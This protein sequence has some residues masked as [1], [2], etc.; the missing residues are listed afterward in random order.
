MNIW[1]QFAT[2]IDG[3]FKEGYSWKSDSTTFEY[4]NWKIIFDNYTLWSG[5][6]SAEMTRVIAPIT[7]KE[8]FRFEIYNESFVRKIEKV[9]GAQDIVIG[10]EDFDKTFIVKSNN[11]FKIKTLLRNK[12]LRNLVKIQKEVNIQ[13]LNEKGI[14]EEKLP[15]NE[16]ELSYFISGEIKNIETLKSLL[17]LFKIMLDELYE[18][19]SIH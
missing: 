1:K 13:I 10:Y 19:N 12:E 9:F 14:W 7:L 2:E 11:E 8:N 5:K 4:K 18:M 15:E 16:F 3:T 6:Y 17:N